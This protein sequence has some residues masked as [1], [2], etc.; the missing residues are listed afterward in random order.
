MGIGF[1]AAAAGFDAEKMRLH[2]GVAPGQQ[3]HANARGGFQDFPLGRAN[4]AL[5]VAI[6]FKEGH[7]VGFVVAGDAPNVEIEQ[8]IWPRSSALRNPTE[9]PVA[10]ATWARESPRRRRKRRKR[11]PGIWGASAGAA[12]TPCFFRT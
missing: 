6:G 4:M 11:W 1:P 5:G 10:R 7:D 9:T 8:R 2:G 3:F 12:T